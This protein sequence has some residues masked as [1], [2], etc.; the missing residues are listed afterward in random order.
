MSKLDD[1][2]AGLSP[3]Q[4]R[5]LELRLKRQ[6]QDAEKKRVLVSIRPDGTR[7]PFFCM[8]SAM[9]SVGYYANLARHLHPDQPF[10]GVQSLGLEA[11]QEPLT[12]V[13][14]MAAYYLDAI[15]LVQA[16]GPYRLGGHSSGGLIAFEMARQLHRQGEGVELLVLLDTQLPDRL[17]AGGEDP[18]AAVDDALL[19]VR[20]TEA[21]GLLVGR[22]LPMSREALQRLEPEAQ[23]D[24]V[25]ET[26]I[27]SN[28]LPLPQKFGSYPAQV[29]RLLLRRLLRVFNANFSAAQNYAPQPYAG[30]IT[31]FQVS[32]R[33]GAGGRTPRQAD[34]GTDAGGWERFSSPPP[35]VHVV[36]G[37]HVTMMAEPGVG[38]VAER[39]NAC[40]EGLPAR[41]A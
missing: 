6:H 28:A 14:E 37:D 23:L 18:N 27:E 1:L 35:E 26:L 30:V 17:L 38:A 33:R 8:H 16:Q 5:L 24:Y 34:G 31:L 22:S 7:R 13:E 40:L 10:Y 12:R 41:A 20:L 29:R 4:R 2:L 32:E 3:E 21:M 19:W 11:E 9:G 25:L 15:R 36:P 39:L